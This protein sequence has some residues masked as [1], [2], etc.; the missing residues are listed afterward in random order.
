MKH[1]LPLIATAPAP[2]YI[3][4]E[5]ADLAEWLVR[6]QP[7][8]FACRLIDEPTPAHLEQ[9]GFMWECSSGYLVDFVW[10]DPQP[11]L[12]TLTATLEGASDFLEAIDDL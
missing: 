3:L 1:P 4:G 2:E 5:A 9:P 6:L 10:L 12:D 7:P 11:D 8:R